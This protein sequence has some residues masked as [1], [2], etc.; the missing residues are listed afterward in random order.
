MDS[1]CAL[2]AG[3]GQWNLPE[4][5]RLL[6]TPQWH[7]HLK[8]N[9]LMVPTPCSSDAG[10]W[11]FFSQGPFLLAA[12]LGWDGGGARLV[13]TLLLH[14]RSLLKCRSSAQQVFRSMSGTEG[15]PV[16]GLS[17]PGEHGDALSPAHGQLCS[18][19]ERGTRC[20]GPM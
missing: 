20:R 7:R 6:R 9:R 2:G 1:V 8:S 3:E 14:W 12:S 15:L 5:L 18:L 10:V 4:V 19:E 16:P 11:P 17:G 13:P